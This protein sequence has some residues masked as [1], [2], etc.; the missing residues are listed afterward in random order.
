MKRILFLIFPILFFSACE[1]YPTPG[2]HIL[3]KFNFQ[4]VGADQSAEAGNY[5]PDSVGIIIDFESLVPAGERQFTMETEVAEG[6]GTIDQTL[7]YSD[8][9]GKM[10]TRW[11]VGDQSNEQILKVKIYDTEGLFYTETEIQATSFIPGQW[12]TITKGYLTKIHDMVVDTINNRTLMLAGCNLFERKEKFHNWKKHPDESNPCLSHIEMNSQGI[13]YAGK[14]NGTLYKSE[15]WGFH[16][17]NLGKPIPDNNFT[18]RLN[19][20]PD[21]Y[22][23]VSR[24]EHGIHCSKDGGKTW[25]KNLSGLAIEE[26]MNDVYMLSDGSHLSLS[27]NQLEILRSVDDGINWSPI[28]TPIY[29]LCFY[30]SE[31]DEIIAFNQENGFS[32]YK[33]TDFGQSFKRVYSAETSYH[34][35]PMTNIFKKHNDTYYFVAPGSGVFKT[36][37]FENFEKILSEYSVRHLHIDHTGTLYANG[38][39]QEPAYILPN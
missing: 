24:W 14:S 13:L 37:D 23:W 16:W 8:K 31:K 6:G 28:N 9:N 26:E 27:L 19:V 22:I 20:T 17:E 1:Q 15:D 4:I 18:F 3:E 2:T 5:L 10:K 7:V 34:T 38:F 12:N 21:D 39:M 30:V 35:T 32:I 11:K 25:H 36:K 33:S 29:S